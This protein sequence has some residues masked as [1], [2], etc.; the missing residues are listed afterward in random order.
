MFNKIKIKLVS[1]SCQSDKVVAQ[2]YDIATMEEIVVGERNIAFGA[3]F[4]DECFGKN[5]KT[6]R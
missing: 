2:L 5:V 6:E 3:D 4:L 1:I